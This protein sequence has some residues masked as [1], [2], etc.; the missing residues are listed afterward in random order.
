MKTSRIDSFRGGFKR[1]GLPSRELEFLTRQ[2]ATL[3]QAGLP[4]DQGLAVLSEQTSG[5]AAREIFLGVRAAVREGGSFARALGRY[6]IEFSDSYRAVVA[7]GELSGSLPQ[8]LG[9]LADAL[10]TQ[11][12]LKAG[13]LGALAYPIIVSLVAFLI[14]MGLMAY[15]VP[16]VVGVLVAQKQSLPLLTQGLILLSN[17][18]SAWGG[19]TLFLV[20]SGLAVFVVRYR[21][22][23][24]FRI[25]VDKRLLGLPL[26]G[27][28]VRLSE[29]ARFAN[30]LSIMLYGGVALPTA[31]HHSAQALK[32]RW[33]RSQA[34]Q[35]NSLVREGAPLGR[36]L[37][38][39]GAFPNL[40][41]QMAMT[42]ERSGQLSQMLGIAAKE[43]EDGLG[44]RTTLLTAILEP[45]L[46]LI[47]GGVVLLIVMAVM[48]P[49]IEMNSLVR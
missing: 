5:E 40:L 38:S 35:V 30:M 16:Q 29:T 3:L 47:M 8:V 4:L 27:A 42:G 25:K 28:L 15:V 43:F 32:N 37:E 22:R 39:T 11:N 19:L 26:V 49:L 7:A 1:S 9:K 20:V 21:T 12:A 34:V 13:L 23:T 36:A 6:P 45:V 44:Y 18:L 46:I 14:V 2:L 41:V 24:D 48:M 31:L 10:K 33:L 17:A